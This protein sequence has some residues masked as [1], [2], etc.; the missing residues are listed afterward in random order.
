ME[1]LSHHLRGIC[2]QHQVSYLPK[3]SKLQL[4]HLI[5]SDDLMVFT[6]GDLPSVLAIKS[7]LDQFALWSGLSPNLDKTDI[8]FGGVP[9]SVKRLILDQMQFVEGSFPFR[10]LGAPFNTSR[11]T[12]DMYNGLLSKIM[13][14][15]EHWS[16]NLLTYAC[17]V[18]LL[19]SVIFGLNSYWCSSVLLSKLVV[20]QINKLCRNFFWSSDN[21]H[22]IVFKSWSSMCLP[23]DERGF[24]IREIFAWNKALL[25]KLIWNLDQKKEGIWV[26]W[27]HCYYFHRSN[28]WDVIPIDAHSDS[29]RSLLKVRDTCTAALGNSQNVQGFS[30]SR[31]YELFRSRGDPCP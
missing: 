19:N 27:V 3:C 16:V 6:R 28:F 15:I 30:V 20:N 11:V 12:A 4:T 26:S 21:R 14:V 5:F 25:A 23:R 2:S 7:V 24:D 8:Y 17:K 18:Q 13:T 22:K 1:I 31:A 10:Y 29:F 9:M